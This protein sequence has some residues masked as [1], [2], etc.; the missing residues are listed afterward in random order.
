LCGALN[1]SV[2]NEPTLRMLIRGYGEIYLKTGK[3][4]KTEYNKNYIIRRFRLLSSQN[5]IRIITSVLIRL[6]WFAA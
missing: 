1:L 3:I 5:V 6:K 2:K 4:Y